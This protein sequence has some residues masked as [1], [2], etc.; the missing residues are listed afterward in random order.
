MQSLSFQVDP[1]TYKVSLH[2][3]NLLIEASHNEEFLIWSKNL[4]EILSSL[5]SS[6]N[7]KMKPDT[8]FK[9]FS[10]YSNNTLESRVKITFPQKYKSPIDPLCIE[11]EI[12]FLEEYTDIKMIEL[13]PKARNME[14]K[15]TDKLKKAMKKHNDDYKYLNELYEDLKSQIDTLMEGMEKMNYK[16]IDTIK[17]LKNRLKGTEVDES[18]TKTS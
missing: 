8:I 18:D 9:I 3:S 13:E 5:N 7:I 4:D 16:N 15:V 17:K 1:F 2:E 11:I 12:K 10:D 14:D 6:L